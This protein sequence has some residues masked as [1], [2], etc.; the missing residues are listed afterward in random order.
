MDLDALVKANRSALQPAATAVAGADQFS[1]QLPCALVED[2]TVFLTS[3]GGLR[4]Y[5]PCSSALASEPIERFLTLRDAVGFDAAFEA[6]TAD[7]D[8]GEEFVEVWDRCQEDLN[9]EVVCTL[10][11]VVAMIEQA[12]AGWQA[13]PKRMLV[14]AREGNEVASGTVAV[15]WLLAG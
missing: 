6:M 7:D 10:N 8:V 13:T 15:D 4:G 14:V 9:G 3:V 12:K 1:L 11:D 5:L 2:G